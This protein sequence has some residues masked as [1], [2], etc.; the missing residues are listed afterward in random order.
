M[1]SRDAVEL[2]DTFAA[3]GLTLRLTRDNSLM[4]TPA[5]AL[6]DQLRA[7][8]RANK[9]VL[10]AHLKCDVTSGGTNPAPATDPD[11][12]CWPHS[13]A[14]N[15][16]EIDTFM[17]MVVRFTDKGVTMGEAQRM[18][19][20]LVIRDRDSD[21]RRS[22]LECVH[23]QG[24]RRCSNWHAAGVAREGLA[25]SLVTMLQRCGGYQEL[26]N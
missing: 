10:V 7:I 25:Y 12:F 23:L 8:I 3:V 11:R 20:R 14:M 5:K 22:C 15:T 9:A 1:Q 6:N 18:A 24:T 21:D 19:D 2:L 26:K 16:L 13:K 4:V 17:S